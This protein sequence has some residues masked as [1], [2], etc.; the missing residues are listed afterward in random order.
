[1]INNPAAEAV[2]TA[3]LEILIKEMVNHFGQ[4]L[5]N[6]EQEPVRFR[7]QAKIMQHLL[8]CRSGYTIKWQLV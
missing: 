4:E 5:A 6:Y 2:R 3:Q 7:H 8:R 1:M